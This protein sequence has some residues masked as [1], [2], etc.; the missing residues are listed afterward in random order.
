MNA[1]IFKLEK[2]L[3]IKK[4][5]VLQDALARV[6]GLAIITV[7]YRGNPIT[8]HSGCIPFCEAVR[9]DPELSKKCRKCDSRG[10][11]E[12]VRSG[13]PYI[14]RCHFDIIDVAIPISIEDKY[15]G[16]VMA[17]QVKCREKKR[18]LGLE[19]ICQSPESLVAWKRSPLLQR[20]SGQIPSLP[21]HSILEASQMLFHLCNYIVD[22]AK[23]KELILEMYREVFRSDTGEVPKETAGADLS[24]IKDALSNLVTAAYVQEEKGAYPV[25]NKSLL[26]AFDFIYANKNRTPSLSEMAGICHLS[27]SH[28]SRIFKKE[29][30]ES[31]SVYLTNRKVEWAKQLLEKTDLSVTQ[32]SD[33]LAFNEPSYFIK[34]FKKQA[35]LTPSLY[36]KTISGKRCKGNEQHSPDL[37]P[38]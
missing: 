35:G 12:A 29:V 24:Q 37:S 4:W 6:T 9:G 10:G 23:N 8:A 18:R 27:T 1:S 36:R 28:F 20:L 34:I 11:L 15:V 21:F 31:Y 2:I 13:Q 25:T 33:E 22:E 26:P 7:D 3:N 5:Q 14:Y 30:G 32:I 16:A 17:G 19:K 38:S